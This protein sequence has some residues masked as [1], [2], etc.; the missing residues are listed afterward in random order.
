M[1]TRVRQSILSHAGAAAFGGLDNVCVI[2]QSA[3]C[4]SIRR[5]PIYS[6]VWYRQLPIRT[7][8]PLLDIFVEVEEQ[9][10]I[11]CCFLDALKSGGRLN[12]INV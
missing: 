10:S 8:T 12:S 4:T 11:F 5:P 1:V 2:A 9:A 6:V 7:W 3:W